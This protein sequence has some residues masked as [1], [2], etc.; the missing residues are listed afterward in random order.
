MA[1]GFTPK[2]EREFTPGDLTQEQ[3][4]TLAV[5]T[6]KKQG[7]T[8]GHLSESGFIAHTRFS[9]NSYGEEFR[10]VIQDG[11]AGLKSTC[12]G[13][14]MVDWGKNEK[15]IQAFIDT[16]TD[17]QKQFTL[18]ET[19]SL[20]AELKADFVTGDTSEHAKLARYGN[21]KIAGFFSLFVPREGYT[22]TPLVIDLNIIIFILMVING[23]S[24]IAPDSD[25]LIAWGA[26]L[27]PLTMG[28]EWWRLLTNCFLHIGVIHLLMNMYALVYI[29]ILL[30]PYLGNVRYATAYLLT[31]I[32]ASICSLWW[33]DLTIS[34]GASGAIFGLYGVFL[35]MLTTNLIDKKS[36]MSLLYSI[37]I[38]VI[39]NLVNGMKG[40]I[41]NAAHIGGLVSGLI[42]GYGFYPSLRVKPEEDRQYDLTKISIGII[43]FV[44]LFSCYLVYLQVPVDTEKKFLTQ[45]DMKNYDIDK[46]DSKIKEFISS[47]T[48]AL[49]VLKLPKETPKEQLLAEIKNR[50][51]YYWKENIEL[52]YEVENYKLPPFLHHRNK[53][54]FDYCNLRIKSYELIYQTI[55]NNTDL[56]QPQIQDI[57]KQIVKL[58]AELSNNSKHE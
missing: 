2:Y 48:E 44:V 41:D 56:L 6:A 13:G 37:G 4:L 52:I 9:F 32:A 55:E 28:G 54:L 21:E 51:I 34:A 7:W 27:R 45:Q 24:A 11:T 5:E 30:E 33:H 23:I 19:D 40:G 31:G 35:A 1:I 15:N 12:T 16:F 43:S 39:Y 22:I 38:F 46:Y 47:E 20:Y 53:L 25:S 26:N 8:I 42:I 3:F 18:E 57:D 58:I 17:I 14:Q 10:V 29:G 50:G 36:R 49:S